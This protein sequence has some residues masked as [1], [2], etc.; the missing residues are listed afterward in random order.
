MTDEEKYEKRKAELESILAKFPNAEWARN[1]LKYMT[2]DDFSKHPRELVQ[3]KGYRGYCDA[4]VAAELRYEGYD[5][6]V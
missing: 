3:D 6:R 5:R 1:E 2:Q 4:A